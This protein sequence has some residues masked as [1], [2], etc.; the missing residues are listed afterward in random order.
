MATLRIL[1][2]GAAQAVTERV[3][4][5]FRR[6]TGHAVLAEFSAVG[7]MKARVL[8]GEAVDFI[9]LTQAMIDELVAAGRIVAGSR[10]DLGRVDT[11][12]AVRASGVAPDVSDAEVL[13]ELLLESSVIVCPDPAVA[14]AG[15]IVMNLVEKLGIAEE[16]RA[17][18]RFF[19]NGY[20]AM[21]WLAAEGGAGAV[22]ITQVTEI[23]PNSGVSYAGPLP[24]Q[25][26][27]KTIYSAGLALEAREPELARDF[28][29]RYSG[30]AARVLLEQAGYES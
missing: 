23:L 28:I 10:V 24:A 14:T 19:P 13:R 5:A 26:Q 30:S 3:I 17:R 11:G 2:A 4:E 20:A 9:I 8:A 15:K 22:G 6:E 1:S 29:T 12:V 21:A 27:M 18:M 7:A 25:F 16:V